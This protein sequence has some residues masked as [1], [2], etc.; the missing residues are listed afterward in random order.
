VCGLKVHFLCVGVKCNI[1]VS[2]ICVDHLCV[3]VSF[4]SMTPRGEYM[5]LNANVM[6]KCICNSGRPNN[7]GA[8]CAMCKYVYIESM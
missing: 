2:L 8:T 4:I 3:G 1:Y 6:D 5:G 7:K